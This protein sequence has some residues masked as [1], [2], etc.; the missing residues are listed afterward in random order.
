MTA[1][2]SET[3]TSDI[4][5]TV[6]LERDGRCATVWI[7]RPPLNILDLETLEGLDRAFEQLASLDGLQMVTVRGGGERA[8]SAGV[9]IEDHIGERIPAMLETF[10]RALRRLFSLEAPT[11]AAVDGHCLGGGMEL[12]AV[13]DLVVAT[14]RSTFGQPEIKLACFAPVAAALYPALFGPSLTYDLLL[15]GRTL[16]SREAE[17]KGFLARRVPHG[18]L[19]EALEQLRVELSSQSAVALRLCKRAIRLGQPQVELIDRALS[20]TEDLYLDELAK[21]SDM[22]EG[23]AAFMEKRAPAWLH[24]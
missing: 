16:D 18:G 13:C 17:A 21:T 20:A 8:F 9:A 14:E 7:E 5:A 19:D 23:V 11:V 22:E 3:C 10:H 2:D 15:T 1:L 6:R 4:C 24:R 12:A